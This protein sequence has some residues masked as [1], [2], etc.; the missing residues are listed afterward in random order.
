MM[1]EAGN[2]E[3]VT[4]KSLLHRMRESRILCWAYIELTRDKQ[5]LREGVSLAKAHGEGC[6]AGG[7]TVMLRGN[8][9]EI[10]FPLAQFIPIDQI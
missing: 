2:T 9:P 4:G 6:R 7:W 3:Y 8:H 5:A 10:Y 1:G